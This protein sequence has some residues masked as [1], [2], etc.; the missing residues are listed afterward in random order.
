MT[1]QKPDSYILGL[2]ME[3]GKQLFEK[4]TDAKY[5]FYPASISVLNAGKAYIYGEYFD[6]NANISKTNRLV[7]LFGVLMKKERS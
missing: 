2:D 7:L 3:T 6:V 4:T 5:R 1:D